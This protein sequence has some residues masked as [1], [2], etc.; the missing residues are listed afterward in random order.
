MS[1]LSH[2]PQYIYGLHDIGGQDELLNAHRPGWV[3]DSVDLRIQAGAD[4][5][6]LSEAGLGVIVRLNYGEP[7]H[8]TIP[9]SRRY[10]AFA[11][12]CANYVENSPGAHIWVIGNEMNSSAERPQRP[13]GSTEIITPTKYARCFSRC[14][15]AIKSLPG[16]ADDWVIPGAAAPGAGDTGDWVRYLVNILNLLADEADGIA[17]HCYTR[18]FSVHQIVDEQMMSAPFNHRHVNFRAYRDFMNALP[19]RFRTL[20]V[21]ITETGPIDGW[22][23]ENVGWI[24]SAYQEIDTWNADR[25]HQP[26]QALILYR[27]QTPLDHPEWGI[28]DK[29]ALIAD[30]RTALDRG[31]RIRFLAASFREP[32]RVGLSSRVGYAS[33][34][35][36]GAQPSLPSP[37]GK[38]EQDQDGDTTADAALAEAESAAIPL[39][40]ERSPAGKDSRAAATLAASPV[41]SPGPLSEQDFSSPGATAPTRPSPASEHTVVAPPPA[42]LAR[43]KAVA[44]EEASGQ[45]PWA[46]HFLAH[47]TP[48]SMAVGQLCA[49]NLR[50]KNIGGKTWPKEGDAPVHV[51]YKWFS[52]SGEQLLDVEDRR[53]VLPFDIEPN[54][55]AAFGALLAAPQTPGSYY[56]RWDLVVEGLTWFSDAGNPPLVLPLSV[57]ELPRDVSGWRVE[58]SLN[59]AEVAYA[60]DGDPRTYWNS[61]APQ[62]V[63]QWFRLNLSS[64]RIV[65]GIQ[66]LS[67]GKGFPKGYSLRVS[68]DGITWTEVAQSTGNSMHDVMVVF[69]P[70]RM[71]Y[72]QI[73]LVTSASSSWMV[74]E[75]LIHPATPWSANASHNASAAVRAIDNR[76]DTFWSSETPQEAGMWFQIDLGHV[77]TVSGLILAPPSKERVAGFRI[78]TWNARANRWQVAFERT[79]DDGPVEAMFDATQTQFINIQLL[80]SS[81]RPWAIREARILREMDAWLGPTPQ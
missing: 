2:L 65:D 43:V 34:S 11:A 79:D 52:R 61:N 74:S 29:P 67:P 76:S 68:A 28:Q 41:T 31:Y 3:L 17:L 6:S 59:P 77:E 19:A 81:N 50:V 48:V 1:I 27:W 12:Q 66:F 58:A 57:T 80:Q 46:L 26:I 7:P 23:D 20:P 73:D 49:V 37:L 60:L 33:R 40:L 14:R 36:P 78:A 22:K 16:H 51:G 10:D 25:T 15:T 24:Q 39:D 56:L 62:A 38:P 54:Q 75:I 8:G 64:P 55:E 69:A 72:A 71:Q 5:S 70:Q 47:D 35:T 44:R 4:Y 13:D 63:G 32:Q 53:T 30:F 18:D 45:D 21:F 42:P 9:L